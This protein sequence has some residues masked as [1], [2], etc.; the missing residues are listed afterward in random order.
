MAG[1]VYVVGREIP[2]ARFI[3]RVL[4]DKATGSEVFRAYLR[5]AGRLLAFQVSKE[6]SWKEARVETPL[7]EA[8]ELEPAGPVDVIGVLGAS[9]PMVEGFVDVLPFAR[10]GLI[11]AR[12]I[13]REG[14]VT[15]EISYVRLPDKI[16][17]AV[18]VDP[19]LATGST[20]R[21]AVK[22]AKE[23]GASRVVIASVIAA[24]EGVRNV[25][26]AYPD[27]TIYTLALDPKLNDKFFIVP[28]LGDAG[29]RALGT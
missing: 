10:V 21:E 24:E 5:Q 17:T 29:D 4:R 23:R 8:V 16:T 12:R 22:I 19:M 13:E 6:L 11:A 28:G 18:I 7:G 20:A 2:A 26:D 25:S 14:G 1:R 3:L 9:I 27:V 15:V